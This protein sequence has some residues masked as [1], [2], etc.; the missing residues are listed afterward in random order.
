MSPPKIDDALLL[1]RMN[2]LREV[3]VFSSLRKED[4]QVLTEHFHVRSYKKKEIIF[5]QGDESHVLYVVMRGRVRIFCVT[6]SGN[7]T[8]VRVFSVNDIIGEFSLIDGQPRSATGQAVTDCT[9]LAMRQEKFLHCLREIPELA[10]SF[11]RL[12]V[13]KLRWCTVFAETIA[14]YDVGGRLLHFI[15][16]YNTAIGKEIEKG[17]CYE[18]DIGLSQEDLASMV[19]ARRERVNHLL[20]QWREQ[21]LIA[22]NRGKITILD[23]GAVEA[24]RNRRTDFFSEDDPW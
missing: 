3:P 12:L 19:G 22:F 18:V 15:L 2:F 8:S 1:K 21:G 17:K 4:L 5:H 16:Y 6:P 13:Q 24:E 11:L 14:Q 10:M 9:L 23:L 7:E 20:G